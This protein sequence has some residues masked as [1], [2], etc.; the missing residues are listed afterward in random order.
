MDLPKNAPRYLYLLEVEAFERDP[1]ERDR[2][3]GD[4][5]PAER[6][7]VALE[8]REKARIYAEEAARLSPVTEPLASA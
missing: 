6:E 7:R 2:L 4:W 1:G 8:C 5:L 3:S